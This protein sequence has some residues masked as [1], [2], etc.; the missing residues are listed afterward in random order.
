MIN[1]IVGRILRLPKNIPA[2]SFSTGGKYG[3]PPSRPFFAR[4]PE[5]EP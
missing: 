4:G 1:K 2:S 5:K 3:K